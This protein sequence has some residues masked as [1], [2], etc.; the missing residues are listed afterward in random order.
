MCG[1]TE[2][3]IVRN[4]WR[5]AVRLLLDDRWQLLQ[6]L[7]NRF[8]CCCCCS[9]WRCCSCEQRCA[10]AASRPPERTRHRRR[11]ARG[12]RG[13]PE[14]LVPA[15]AF[16][17]TALG[18]GFGYRSGYWQRWRRGSRPAI[19]PR[20]RRS[21]GRARAAEAEAEVEVEVEAE[22][23]AEAQRGRTRGCTRTRSPECS[24]FDCRRRRPRRRPARR[25]LRRAPDGTFAIVTHSFT[26]A[27]LG[28][29]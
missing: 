1:A 25:D 5:T 29:L 24:R 20:E 2:I 9:C 13:K 26:A 6:L 8:C 15:P 14:R 18:F 16:E 21:A 3:I 4:K 19:A 27:R 7:S 22:V 11:T 10:P 23:E 28:T 17:R 12:P